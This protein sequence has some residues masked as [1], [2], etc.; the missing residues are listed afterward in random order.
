[1]VLNV[2]PLGCLPYHAKTY[3]KN[4]PGS[5]VDQNGCSKDQND[6]IQEFNKQLKARI[7]KL[8]GLNPNAALTYVDVYSAKYNLISNAR[9]LGKI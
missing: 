5:A 3:P 6:L 9:K 7:Q 4:N 8:R 1:M 2:G